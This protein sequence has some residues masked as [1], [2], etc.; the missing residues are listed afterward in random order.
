MLQHFF[1]YQ[2]V[3]PRSVQ[4]KYF[5]MIRRKL[6]DR[7]YLLKSR[8]D[9]E[10]DRNTYTKTF[11]NFSYK[12]YRFHFGIFL[13]CHYST[14]DESSPEYGHTCRVPSPYV[15]SF[16]RRGCVQH[17]KYIDFFQNVKKRNGSMQVSPNNRISH[18][19]RLFDAWA[20]STTKHVYSK[21]LGISYDT[22]Y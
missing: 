8:G 5:N 14:L 16:Y 21:R 15:M 17:Q 20:S 18:A 13:P 19:T 11:F 3:I 2:N 1:F 9:K 6:L 4:H 12:L 22:R 7:Y 10:T